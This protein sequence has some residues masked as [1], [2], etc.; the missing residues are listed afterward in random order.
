M[1]PR[2]NER[3]RAAAAM[4]CL[5]RTKHGHGRREGFSPTFISYNSMKTRCLNSKFRNFHLWGGRGI[6]ICERWLGE[7]GF[8]NF[9]AD[10]GERPPGT[11]LERRNNNGD[12]EPGN[13]RWA[14]KAE[15]GQNTGRT[16]LTADMVRDIR[17]R[18]AAGESYAQL[19]KRFRISKPTIGNVV[20]RATWKNVE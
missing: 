15:Q 17:Q 6:K 12:Y 10:M 2:N 7:R 14:T 9:L 18:S 11:T 19:A 13:C 1:M 20:T 3:Q 5:S 4:T 16:K 8:V